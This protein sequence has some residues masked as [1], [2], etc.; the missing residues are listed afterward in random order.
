[1]LP[2]SCLQLEYIAQVRDN[3]DKGRQDGHHWLMGPDIAF[4]ERRLTDAGAVKP[5]PLQD[6]NGSP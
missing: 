3:F 5:E 2:H 6:L 1:M 4:V